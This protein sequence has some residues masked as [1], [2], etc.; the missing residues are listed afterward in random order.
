VLALG[1]FDALHKG[2]QALAAAALQLG[3]SPVLLSF[4]GMAA[5]LGWP[6]R[7]PLVAPCDRPRVLQLWAQQLA[8]QQQQ[9]EAQ[10]Q[11]VKRQRRQVSAQLQQHAPEPDGAA[12]A[13]VAQQQHQQQQQQQ[14]DPVVVPVRQR[15]IPF[16]VVRSLS[17][18]AFVGHIV[19][20]FRAA[21]V[22][23]GDNY[24][25]GKRRGAVAAQCCDGRPAPAACAEDASSC[26][27]LLPRR[28]QGSRRR[29]AAAAAVRRRG[30]GLCRGAAGGR[31]R[32]R[33]SGARVVLQGARGLLRHCDKQLSPCVWQLLQLAD[34][35]V[36][37]QWR[38]M[39]PHTPL[40]FTQTPD[41]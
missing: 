12:V 21:G 1:K 31:S 32:A 9:H 41:S 3:G 30:A 37:G 10:Q 18:E 11:R 36:V 25:F 39:M 26:L 28:L 38:H 20:D 15:Y 16:A 29:C 14:Q 19:Q 13:A 22:V 2:H 33:R 23:A 6:Q 27:V 34:T 35:A 24:R 4:S 17:P 8:E 40:L 5:V 7:K